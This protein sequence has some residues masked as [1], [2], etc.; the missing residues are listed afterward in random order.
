MPDLP[1]VFVCPHYLFTRIHFHFH[2]ASREFPA[3]RIYTV[4]PISAA[5]DARQTDGWMDTGPHFI[6]SPLFTEVG[7]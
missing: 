1:I 2:L 6:M 7:G 3:V 5:R 4:Q